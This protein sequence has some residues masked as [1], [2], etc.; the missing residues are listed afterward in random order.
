VITIQEMLD[1]VTLRR[2]AK[3]AAQNRWQ[4]RAENEEGHSAVSAQAFRL[5]AGGRSRRSGWA[6]LAKL[7]EIASRNPTSNFFLIQQAKPSGTLLRSR[8][9]IGS[10]TSSK[11]CPRIRSQRACSGS[12]APVRHL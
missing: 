5:E 8:P 3:P 12:A 7:N 1:D 9:S 11:S 10:S 6:T 2:R 4:M